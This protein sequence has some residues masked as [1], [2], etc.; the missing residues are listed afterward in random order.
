MV[1]SG[2]RMYSRMVERGDQDLHGREAPLARRVGHQPL[3]DDRLQRRGHQVADLLVLVRREERDDAADGLGRVDGVHGAE[4]QVARV[5]GRQRDLHRLGVADLA[6]EDHVRILA[7]DVPQRLGVA[8]GV[9]ADLALADDAPL[10][11]VQELDRILDG[12]DVA[13]SGRC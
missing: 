13:A 4:H 3:R 1:F 5:G 8:A 7:Q 12:D 11:A 10:V 6:D 2:S 9:G